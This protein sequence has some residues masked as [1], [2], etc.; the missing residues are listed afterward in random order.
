MNWTELVRERIVVGQR[1]DEYLKG[2]RIERFGEF[3]NLTLGTARAFAPGVRVN[4]I[5]PGPFLTDIS[6][7]WD[8]EAFKHH[9]GLEVGDLG[10]LCSFGAGY[11]VGSVLLRRSL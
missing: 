11:S 1:D 9:D 10:V 5:M 7:A 3:N 4:C 8:L 2:R 6:K